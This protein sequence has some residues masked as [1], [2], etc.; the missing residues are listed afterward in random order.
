M[1]PLLAVRA[2]LA[3]EAAVGRSRWRFAAGV[4]GH[5]CSKSGQASR[6]LDDAFVAIALGTRGAYDKWLAPPLLAFEYGDLA[7]GMWMELWR[8]GGV[9][10]RRSG[11]RRS[12]VCLGRRRRAMRGR[13]VS[14]AGV[15]GGSLLGDFCCDGH[16]VLV[17]T[18]FS[19]RRR[20]GARPGGH[21]GWLARACALTWVCACARVG[22][23]A[24]RC[25]GAWAPAGARDWRR[26]RPKEHSAGRECPGVFGGSRHRGP[27][28]PCRS[29]GARW[30]C[31]RAGAEAALGERGHVSFVTS[32]S[33]LPLHFLAFSRVEVV[34]AVL[35]KYSLAAPC[36]ERLLLG[37]SGDGTL[38]LRILLV[39][40]LFPFAFDARRHGSVASTPELVR[41]KELRSRHLVIRE[42][43]LRA[44][45]RGPVDA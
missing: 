20:T 28:L 34:W 24:R 8:A 42:L 3:V 18:I 13:H 6:R 45:A 9:G 44:P 38:R 17:T 11:G 26:R 12:C 27:C 39:Y 33:I 25:V 2:R 41:L 21:A 10:G 23:R 15:G 37:L 40:D 43:V 14:P 1:W 35:L 32:C 29:V 19:Q 5:P 22:A 36:T 7:A 4:P 30:I 31:R 16:V